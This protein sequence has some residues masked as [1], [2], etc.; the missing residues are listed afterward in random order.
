LFY[1]GVLSLTGQASNHKY[2]EYADAGVREYWLVD[3][4]PGKQNASFWVLD[5]AGRY[6]PLPVDQDGVFRS[7]VIPGFWL[8]VD[9]L[10]ANEKLSPLLLFAE[11]VGLP[12]NIVGALKNISPLS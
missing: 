3:S 11:I 1:V 8:K 6:Q 5:T 7:T 10:W 12:E 2:D 4:R 9:W